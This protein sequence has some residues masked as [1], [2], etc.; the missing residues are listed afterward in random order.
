MNTA[1]QTSA[2][3]TWG[4][5][6]THSEV[7]FKVRHLVI[8][9][10]TGYFKS[11]DIKATAEDGDWTTGKVFFSADIDSIDT[12]Q[13]Q[14]DGHLKSA[15]FFDAENH[16]QLTFESTGIQKV[17][18]DTYKLIG[19]LT[20]RGITK[21]IELDVEYGGET[22]D[23]YGNYKAGFEVTGKIKRKEYGLT[24]DAVTEAGSV[25]VS[26]EVKL[27]ANVQLVKQG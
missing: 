23:F 8:S 14:R 3:T 6:P 19:D 20:I 12:G 7:Q 11:Y 9:T 16:P 18:D 24:W 17:S 10:V 26:D 27:F 1:T 13:E 21:P 5:D 25:V 15:D 22:T 4:V 2:I